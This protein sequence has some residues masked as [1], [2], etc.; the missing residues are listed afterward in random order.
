MRK[1]S[2]S[3]SDIRCFFGQLLII[4]GMVWLVTTGLCTLGF[5]LFIT[6]TYHL[7]TGDLWWIV[8]I[9]GP[10]ALIGWGIQMLGRHFK[11]KSP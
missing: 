1:S 10:S 7:M 4:V 6:S 3:G 11:A 9:G 8:G 5:L 2:E